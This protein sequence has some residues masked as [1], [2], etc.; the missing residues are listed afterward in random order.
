MLQPEHL[1]SQTGFSFI[2]AF[3]PF[4]LLFDDR[5]MPAECLGFP[6][7]IEPLRPP[8]PQENLDR[9]PETEIFHI[10]DQAFPCNRAAEEA[11]LNIVEFTE[12]NIVNEMRERAG[13]WQGQEEMGMIRN[14]GEETWLSGGGDRKSAGS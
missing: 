13:I 8:S 1:V 3:F 12:I 10:T 14:T 11:T 2:A 6:R 7:R 9:V 5:M 4:A